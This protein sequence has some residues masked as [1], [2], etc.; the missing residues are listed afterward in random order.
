MENNDLEMKF[1]DPQTKTF[2][3]FKA[4]NSSVAFPE[5]DIILFF[6]A[7]DKVWRIKNLKHLS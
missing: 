4:E 5:Q 7:E 2:I 3:D 6:D 1:Y